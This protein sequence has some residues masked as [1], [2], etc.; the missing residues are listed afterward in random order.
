MVMSKCL[1]KIYFTLQKYNTIYN[2]IYIRYG[3]IVFIYKYC[4]HDIKYIC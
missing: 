1:Y 4:K 2:T 3:W